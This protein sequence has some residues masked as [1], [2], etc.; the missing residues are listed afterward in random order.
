MMGENNLSVKNG[1][2]Y[3]VLDGKQCEQ[4]QINKNT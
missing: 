4:N 3:M 2:V 1:K